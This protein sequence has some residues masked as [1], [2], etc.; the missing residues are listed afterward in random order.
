MENAGSASLAL[1]SQP[2]FSV[3]LLDETPGD[4]YGRVSVRT[5]VATQLLDCPA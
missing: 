2:R 3:T 1:E 5:G 4:S